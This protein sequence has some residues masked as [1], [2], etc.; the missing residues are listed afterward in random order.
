MEVAASPSVPVYLEL[1]FREALLKPLKVRVSNARSLF[2]HNLL[3]VLANHFRK[4][5]F[6]LSCNLPQLEYEISLQL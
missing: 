4:R 3:K 6:A 1:K 2:R 5:R